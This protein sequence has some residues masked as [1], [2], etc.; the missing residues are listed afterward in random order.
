MSARMCWKAFAVFTTVTLILPASEGWLLL[1]RKRVMTSLASI[2]RLLTEVVLKLLKDKVESC[3]KRYKNK[4]RIVSML[5]L[6][7]K[8][9]N[10]KAID[11]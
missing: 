7:N 11:C 6:L 1:R 5:A 2:S 8:P 9:T 3:L 4:C 10:S